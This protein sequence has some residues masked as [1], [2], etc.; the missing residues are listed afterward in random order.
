MPDQIDLE[1][2]R[3][4][5]AIAP[6]TSCTGLYPSAVSAMTAVMR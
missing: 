1:Q 4:A 2:D 5:S 6:H 3:Y